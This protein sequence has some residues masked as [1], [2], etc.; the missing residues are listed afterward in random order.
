[1]AKALTQAFRI[2][3]EAL[4]VGLREWDFSAVQKN[5][6]D[7]WIQFDRHFSGSNM[8]LSC[9][10]GT[11][12]SAEPWMF[13][14]S[15]GENK[16]PYFWNEKLQEWFWKPIHPTWLCRNSGYLLRCLC[17][18]HQRVPKWLQM[19]WDYD[20]LHRNELSTFN[21]FLVFNLDKRL[22]C[23]DFL[24][25]FSP[26]SQHSESYIVL[27]QSIPWRA[28]CAPLRTL[29]KR[30]LR[31]VTGAL[32]LLTFSVKI[33]R[34]IVCGRGRFYRDRRFQF[35]LVAGVY[36]KEFSK[37]HAMHIVCSL[38]VRPSCSMFN[39]W[40][41]GIELFSRWPVDFSAQ[42]IFSVFFGVLS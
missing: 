26:I 13:G 6:T 33:Q 4:D 8:R 36:C 16:V 14:K 42:G 21:T 40:R 31:R 37:A 24:H 32:V 9:H 18:F 28:T 17:L 3:A 38:E 22:G 19:V 5:S 25:V 1:M 39:I 20:L 11:L 30:W 2:S 41:Q 27:H 15:E 10:S 7:T 23:S 12:R 29:C 35:W 34:M